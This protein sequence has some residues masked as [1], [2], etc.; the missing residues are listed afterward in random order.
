MQTRDSHAHA[1]ASLM[2]PWSLTL[3]KILAHAARWH[4]RVEIVSKRLDGSVARSTY[5]TIERRA[6]QLSAALLAAG[7]RPG[8]RVATLAMNSHEHVEAW[9]AMAGIGVVCHTLNPRLFDEQLT[10]IIEHA[11]DRW[12]FADAVF[13]PQLARLLPACPSVERVVFFG[14][15]APDAVGR[16]PAIGYEAL[17]AAYPPECRWGDFDENSPAG[18]CYT[19]GTTGHP[20]GVLYSHRSQMLHTLFASSA[21]GMGLTARDTILMVVPMFHAN[22]WGVPFSAALVGTKLV[23]PGPKLDG[24]SVYGLLESERAT[25]SC[26]VPTVWQLLLEHMRTKQLRLS[27]LKRVLIGGS[28]CPDALIRAFEAHGVEVVHAWGMTEMSPIG[29]AACPSAEIAALPEADRHALRLK[30]GRVCLAVDMKITDE[31]G[32]RLAHDGTQ[33]GHVKVRGPCIISRYFRAEDENVLD[34]EGFFDTGDIGT[35]DRYGYLQITDRAKDLIKSGG[36]WISS[37]EVENVAA[38]HPKALMAAVIAIPHPKWRERPLLIVKLRPGERATAQE[39]LD[40]LDGKIAKWWMP[41]AVMFVDEI[42]L[43]GTGKIDKKRLRTLF[44]AAPSA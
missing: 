4:P 36:E 7:I 35:I 31:A 11:Q 28:A 33:P 6:R 32:R 34:A 5:E 43:G 21:D 12:I 42:P 15:G 17:I 18:L 2:Q 3:D 26:A 16:V 37:V 1:P 9:Y 27:T 44:P 22:A 24:E 8:E 40:H 20:K 30:Q 41:D 13:A 19:S 29:T 23:L 39:F 10:Y 38:G 14:D 25:V